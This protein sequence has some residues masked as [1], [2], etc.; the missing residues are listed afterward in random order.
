MHSRTLAVPNC[1]SI[2]AEGSCLTWR[3]LA[4]HLGPIGTHFGAVGPILDPLEEAFWTDFGPVGLL[5][6]SAHG[7]RGRWPVARWACGP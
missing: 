7:A 3:V 2:V 5:A 6:R 4:T 1:L